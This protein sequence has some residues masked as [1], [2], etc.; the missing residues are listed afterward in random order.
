MDEKQPR[1]YDTDKEYRDMIDDRAKVLV[2]RKRG[3]M[4]YST[5]RN[6]GNHPILDEADLAALAIVS[7]LD[8]RGGVNLDFDDDLNE[9]VADTL[10]A[11]IR[12]AYNVP[13]TMNLYEQLQP[14]ERPADLW[15][16]KVK[17][18]VEAIPPGT[19]GDIAG[20][21]YVNMRDGKISVQEAI[22]QVKQASEEDRIENLNE[23][24]RAYMNTAAK[25]AEAE[26]VHKEE[27]CYGVAR[28][29]Y[30]M[31]FNPA[32]ARQEP[33]SDFD[34]GR[35][36]NEIFDMRFAEEIKA[37]QIRAAKELFGNT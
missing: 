13:A 22:E 21:I 36:F 4:G 12:K 37:R 1:R 8:G 31:R 30:L 14:V 7:E 33:S 3:D 24:L 11:I 6:Y 28:D 2:E 9:E 19:P 26:G 25:W 35:V 27:A 18:F 20:D 10:S 32:I 15:V 5:D 29:A 34:P 23:E 17:T 16:E